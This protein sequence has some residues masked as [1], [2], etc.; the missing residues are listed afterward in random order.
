MSVKLTVEITLTEQA[1]AAIYQDIW[2]P[3]SFDLREHLELLVLQE[4]SRITKANGLPSEA[5]VMCMQAAM[6]NAAKKK[7]SKAGGTEL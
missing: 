6:N 4:V 1:A 3:E 5:K 7:A 2:S